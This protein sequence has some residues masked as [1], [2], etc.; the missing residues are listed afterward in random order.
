M[1]EDK[2]FENIRDEMLD[3][4]PDDVD[5][6]EGSLAHDASTAMAASI[7]SAY[8]DLANVHDLTSL[9]TSSG[10]YLDRFASE[11]GIERLR[12][13]YAEYE[14]IYDGTAPPEGSEFYSED[15][16]FFFIVAYDGDVVKLVST[17]VGTNA[18]N[19]SYGTM[20]IPY[21][22]IDGLKSSSFGNIILNAIDDEEDEAL[23]TRIIEKISKP[24]VNGNMSQY[25]S[26]CESIKG[27]GRAIILPLKYG[28]NTV[29][30]ILISPEGTPVD[31]AIVSD[32]QEYVDP[33]NPVF[34]TTYKGSQIS[35]G[36]GYGE[37]VAPIGSHFLASSAKAFNVS[38]SVNVELSESFTIEQAKNEIDEVITAYLKELAINSADKN[39]VRY[40]KIGALIEGLPSVYDYE[41]LNI[42]GETSNLSVPNDSI[43]VL[44]EVNADVVV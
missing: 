36:S 20:A 9:D 4:F 3:K 35:L 43:A 40:S 22:D 19:I 2:T 44:S 12:A 6:R 30:A 1:Y 39:T 24:A 21:E 42:N 23:R 14:L 28:P 41:N 11:H 37:G 33:M 34:E 10:E 7:A 16:E 26:W 25:K 8:V 31:N 15:G 29:E 13:T 32:V 27:V 5:I 18:N 17:E 38:I